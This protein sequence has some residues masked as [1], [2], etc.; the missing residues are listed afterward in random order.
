MLR[1]TDATEE[2]DEAL[3]AASREWR[4]AELL[5]QQLAGETCASCLLDMRQA[6]LPDRVCKSCSSGASPRCCASGWGVSAAPLLAC[7]F[8]T[9][10]ISRRMRYDS[11]V[12]SAL[13][14]ALPLL[15]VSER[16]PSLCDPQAMSFTRPQ[17]P[18]VTPRQTRRPAAVAPAAGCAPRACRRRRRP[19]ASTPTGRRRGG[20]WRR[21]LRGFVETAPS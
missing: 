10:L 14:S 11:P 6:W 20:T 3:E 15:S 7:V 19:S 8:Q 21:R 5:R 1:L 12:A 16:L 2:R 18:L 13:P 17:A 9:C 4:L